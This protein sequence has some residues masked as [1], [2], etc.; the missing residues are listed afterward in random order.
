MP[1]RTSLRS[2]LIA[3][4]LGTILVGWAVGTRADSSRSGPIGLA[5][6][7]APALLDD[8]YAAFLRDQDL[9]AFR[10]RV[11]AR[12]GEPALV[13][14][15]QAQEPDTRRAAVL[16]LGLTGSMA[17]NAAVARALKDPDPGVRGLASAALWGLWGRAGDPEANAALQRIQELNARGRFEE[18]ADAA[19]A[20]IRWAPE[21]AEAHNQR[22]IA[23]FSRGQY[24]ESAADCR[25][26]LELNPYHVGALA[27]LGQCYLRMGQRAEA[28]ETYRRALELQPYHAGLRQ[29]IAEI[30]R[31]EE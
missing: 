14:L 13:R 4:G 30:Q 27:G 22:A 2:R 19:A 5:E 7:A 16:A 8:Y 26:V 11:L 1:R 21:F 9:D 15:V 31:F 3:A 25:K 12:F 23:M 29:I 6:P 18:A 28:L 17:A 10:G 24:A 20:L